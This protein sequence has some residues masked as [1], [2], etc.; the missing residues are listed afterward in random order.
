MRRV[1]ALLREQWS[2]EQVAAYLRRRGEVRISHETIYR[3]VWRD[4]KKGGTLHLHLRGARKNCRKRFGRHDNR[5]R[6]SRQ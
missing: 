5:G 1:E 2:P 4:W 3:H 6:V